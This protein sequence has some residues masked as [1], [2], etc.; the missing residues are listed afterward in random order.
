ML[1][2]FANF[3]SSL[4][5]GHRYATILL[6]MRT[7]VIEREVFLPAPMDVVWEKSFGSGEA[8]SG[9][10]PQTV[11]GDYIQGGVFYL[12]WGEHR[13]QCRL[14]ELNPTTSLAY[15]WHPGEAYNLDAH[16]ESEL[17]TVRFTLAPHDG[18]T[19][20]TMIESG[21]ANIPDPRHAHA[22]GENTGGW[23][24]ELAKLPLQYQEN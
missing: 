9:W 17:T 11:E 5:N 19:L 12:I 14:I 1:P 13:C 4:D 22:L 23:D 10:F 15:Q 2:K 24:E 3:D 21:F 20:V 7:D 8:L 18:G 6:H 16:P